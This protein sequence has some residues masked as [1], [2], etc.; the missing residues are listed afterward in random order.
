MPI[1]ASERKAVLAVFSDPDYDMWLEEDA[2]DR[3]IEAINAVRETAKRFV[4]VANL[5]YAGDA[6]FHLWACGPFNTEL[7]A[8]RMGER[9]A[10]DPATG[11]G[12]AR[13]RVVPILSPTAK[14]A[15]HAWESSSSKTHPCCSL[16]H[17]WLK[18]EIGNWTWLRPEGDVDHWRKG[19][20]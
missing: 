7:Q 16:H 17:G 15:A 1:P 20:W 18:D 8:Q 19:G 13:W 3:I 2:A 11:K 9:F 12:H 4:M 5:K 14:A 6:D 10:S